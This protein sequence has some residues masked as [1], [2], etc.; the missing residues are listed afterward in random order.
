MYALR[1]YC[2]LYW[3]L[4]WG[5]FLGPIVIQPPSLATQMRLF[6]SADEIRTFFRK[7]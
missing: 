2:G 1:P 5:P 6:F 7:G 4:Y 3:G